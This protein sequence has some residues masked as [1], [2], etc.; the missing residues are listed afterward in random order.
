MDYYKNGSGNDR[1]FT[2]ISLLVVVSYPAIFG[3][4][5]RLPLH[6]TQWLRRLCL[7]LIVLR[8]SLLPSV[9][10]GLALPLIFFGA[11]VPSELS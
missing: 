2:E 4:V 8:P 1:A 11:Q 10:L 5:Q 9:L 7:R 6:V 3:W